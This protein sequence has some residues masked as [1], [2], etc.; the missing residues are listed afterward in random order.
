MCLAQNLEE[1]TVLVLLSPA[2]KMHTT[3]AVRNLATTQP[4]MMDEIQ[5]LSETTRTLEPANLKALM[6]ISDALSALNHRRFQ[7][8][9]PPFTDANATPAALTFAGDTYQ[10]LDVGQLSDEDL[11]WAQGRVGILSGL[12]GILRPLDLMQPYRLEMGTSLANPR[13][14]NLYAFWGSAISDVI[15][16]WT[17]S[18]SDKSI[19]NLASNEYFK[20]VKGGALA[21]SVVTPAFKEIRADGPK[22]IG[23][24]A[25]RARGMM[26]RFIVQRRL[27]TPEALKDFNEAGYR[28]DPEGSTESS[29]LFTRPDTT[30]R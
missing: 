12:Y 27:E 16:Q 10:G 29:L 30:G 14:K 28:F 21:G 19:I 6:G 8:F 13:G 3:P 15:N 20:A 2:K 11:Q 26:A 7:D 17:S 5:L 1:Q 22:M 23:F 4:S 25:K 18:H 9:S 24:F